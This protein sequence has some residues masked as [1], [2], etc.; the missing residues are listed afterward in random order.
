MGNLFTNPEAKELAWCSDARRTCAQCIANNLE[1]PNVNTILY[2]L[3]RLSIAYNVSFG[4][5]L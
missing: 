4:S 5:L 2:Q 1:F 3:L